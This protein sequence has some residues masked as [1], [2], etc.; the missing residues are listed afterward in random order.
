MVDL[1]T[2]GW[3]VTPDA[4]PATLLDLAARDYLDPD[5][6]GP[7][8]VCRVRRRDGQGLQPYERRVLDHVAGLAVDGIVPA[9]ALTTGPQ[10]TSSRWWKGFRAEVVADA[11]GRGLARDR[12]SPTAKRLLQLSA[13]APA[14]L[15]TL[16][17]NAAVG[18]ELGTVGAG[19]ATWVALGSLVARFQDLRDTPAGAA[20][21]SR[22]L[23]VREYLRRDEVFRTLPPA[24]VAIWDRYLGYGA[25]L[26]VA[27]AA[28]RALPMGA[29]D[30][31]R[32][33]SSFGGRW[34]V[35]E[36]R[37]PRL[38]LVWGRPPWLALLVGLGVGAGGYGLAQL[39]LGVR[40]LTDGYPGGDR[41]AFWVRWVATGLLLLTVPLL[42]WAATA[43]VRA[44]LDLAGR[45]PVEGQVVRRRAYQRDEH[46]TDYF[47]GV[48]DGRSAKVKAWIV[49]K[50]TYDRLREGTL[51]RATIGPRLGHVFHVEQSDAEA[52]AAAPPTPEPAGAPA[53]AGGAPPPLPAALAGVLLA[54][55][56]QV[57]PAVLVTAEDAGRA[58]GGGGRS[59]Q[60][61]AGA[62]AAGRGAAGLPV[63][64][65]LRRPRVGV[66]VHRGQRR[67]PHARAGE[68][69]VR[70]R[71]ARHRG[72]GL[73]P[74]RR[75]RRAPRRRRRVDPAAEPQGAGPGGHAPRAG[76]R[77]RGPPVAAGVSWRAPGRTAP[78]P[79]RGSRGGGRT[80]G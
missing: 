62:A 25:A 37:Y 20:A 29:E 69:V 6:A 7:R 68:P 34:L 11:R 16:L 8:T 70:E 44:A 48:D 61:A 28:V 35:V 2:N 1:L 52:P 50:A 60:A 18:V 63:P 77:G 79:G 51:V 3:R 10:E 66:G 59:C 21:A 41:A 80:A 55:G 36:V 76:D 27:T 4:V 14:A 56:T 15:G 43:V 22:W 57:D 72:R 32:A 17:L 78:A 75:H 5:Q 42:A 9:E 53:G 30:D 73:P 33:W 71:R 23:G 54:A 19:L 46:H 24:S 49:S 31:H 12:W 67:H 64:G 74:Q 47:V 45:R 65:R 13:A 58:L 39:L 26:G 38:R 40:H